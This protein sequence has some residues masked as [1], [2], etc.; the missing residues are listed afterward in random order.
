MNKLKLSFLGGLKIETGDVTL[1][2]LKSKKGQALLAYLAVSQKMCTRSFLAGLLWINMPE[3]K[4]RANLR[5]T[6]SRMRPF[7]GSYIIS[8]PEMLEF[9]RSADYW[10]DVSEFERNIRLNSDAGKFKGAL[11]LYKGDFLDSFYISDAPLFHDWVLSKRAQLRELAIKGLDYLVNHHTS[12]EDY[13]LAISY[14]KQLLDIEPWYEEA[15][16]MLM[17][18]HALTGQ[19]SAAL[20]QYERCTLVLEDDLGVE[21]SLATKDIYKKIIKGQLNKSLLLEGSQGVNHEIGIQDKPIERQKIKDLPDQPYRIVGRRKEISEIKNLLS[22]QEVQLINILG[23]GGV[24]KTHLA[25]VTANEIAELDHFE[26]SLAF[27]PLVSVLTRD[28]LITAIAE[29]LR[30]SLGSVKDPEGALLQFIRGKKYLLILDNFEHLIDYS[31]LLVKLL[32]NSK[33]CKLLLTSRERLKLHEE[34]V[35]DLEGLPY[36][37]STEEAGSSGY[38]AVQLFYER[39]RKINSQF[40]IENELLGVVRICQLTQGNPLAL[41]LAANLIRVRHA[42][43]IADQIEKDLDVLSTSLRN[44]PERHRSMYAVFYESWRWLS[45]EEQTTLARLSV[46]N[47]S[48]GF[49]AAKEVAEASLNMLAGLIDKSLL[50]TTRGDGEVSRYDFHEL[51]R[52]YACEKLLESGRIEF[53]RTQRRHLEFYLTL[54]ERAR[55]FWDTEEEKDWLAH[56]EIERSNLYAALKWAAENGYV[57]RAL[58]LNA[59]LVTFWVYNSP[60]G[61]ASAWIESALCLP[62]NKNSLSTLKARAHALIVAGHAALGISDLEL[63]R[64]RFQDGLDLNLE[65]GNRTFCA[66]A[67]RGLGLVSAIHGDLTKAQTYLEESLAICQDLQNEWCLAWSLFEMG[68]VAL[69]SNELEKAEI[70]LNDALVIFRRQDRE[71]GIF[72]TM[73]SMGHLRRSQKKWLESLEFFRHALTIQAK[74]GY[75]QFV[76]QI[77]EGVGHITLADNKTETAVLLFG[78]AQARRDKIE[79]QRW[80]HQEIEYQTSLEL[81]KTQIPDNK[82]QAAWNQGYSLDLKKA[83][84]FVL[85]DRTIFHIPTQ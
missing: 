74:T 11:K 79:T 50:R 83:L 57:D 49:E 78:A 33:G 55:K 43:E 39:A 17:G 23:P 29:G 48:F 71:M 2:G 3:N 7:L 51:V 61:E 68:G 38:E 76:A 54:A 18:L 6:L 72:R 5:K 40:L 14:T 19:R 21:P 46:F 77:L 56:I 30:V 53:N 85:V 70:F 34:W 42:A 58:R 12:E 37:K 65:L 45:R 27:I 81:T 73:I 82:W 8:T 16:R 28:Q 41:E 62:W 64:M 47:G 13:E 26:G 75:I 80:A 31:G 69:T 20:M 25:I 59:A 60:S 4:A 84:E 52:H 15:H 32:N 10:L 1:T 66:W 67:L 36:P 35:L 44:L 24:G 9:D 63:A 22:R